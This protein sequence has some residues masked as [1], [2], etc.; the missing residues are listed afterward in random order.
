MN[1]RVVARRFLP[2]LRLP[3]ALPAV[4]FAAVILIG[5]ALLWLP[6]SHT[7]DSVSYLDAL[8]TAT[9]AVCVTGLTT[10]STATDFTVA[11]P[12]SSSTS[13]V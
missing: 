12:H 2:A 5:S 6:W 13:L 4:G 11:R 7:D 8:F 1:A 9:S 10:V 3:Q